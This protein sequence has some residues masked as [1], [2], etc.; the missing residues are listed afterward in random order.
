MHAMIWGFCLVACR[1]AGDQ[2]TDLLAF[3]GAFPQ[4]SHGERK[5]ALL[6]FISERGGLHLDAL[7]L[8]LLAR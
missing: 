6:D 3:V 2:R 5:M 4:L 1:L 7:G 8:D